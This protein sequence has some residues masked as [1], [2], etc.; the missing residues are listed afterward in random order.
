PG[1]HRASLHTCFCSVLVPSARLP[2]GLGGGGYGVPVRRA[3]GFAVRVR[4][5]KGGRGSGPSGGG[6]SAVHQRLNV[7]SRTVCS[8]SGPGGRLLGFGFPPP[9][10]GLQPPASSLRPPASSLQL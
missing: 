9:A 6:G 5:R 3:V 2:P 1:G 8:R 7:R 10:I 4:D